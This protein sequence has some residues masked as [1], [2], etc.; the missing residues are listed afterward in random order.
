MLIKTKRLKIEPVTLDLLRKYKT[1][2]YPISKEMPPHISWSISEL[3]NDASFLGWGVWLIIE[4]KTNKIIGDIGFKGK[5]NAQGVVEMGYGV[6]PHARKNGY[7]TE[8]VEAL[9]HWAF[10]ADNVKKI[11]ADCLIDNL[12]STKVLKKLGMTQIGSNGDLLL[13]ELTNT[14]QLLKS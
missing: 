1:E 14:N 4:A 13:W 2:E 8:A 10:D 6:L 11:L 9:C 3:E 5:P 12:P 7:A